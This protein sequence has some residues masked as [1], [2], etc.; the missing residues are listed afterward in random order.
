LVIHDDAELLAILDYLLRP[1][2]WDLTPGCDGVGLQS[3]GLQL[4]GG[5]GEEADTLTLRLGASSHEEA[6]R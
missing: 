4:A 2:D 3:L 5:I 6:E 1:D